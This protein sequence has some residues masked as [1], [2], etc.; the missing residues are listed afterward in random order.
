MEIVQTV[1]ETTHKTC[2]YRRITIHLQDKLG[3]RINHKA[4]FRL[5]RKLGIRSV[6]RQPYPYWK[7]QNLG[8]FHRYENLLNRDFVAQA[9]NQKW[10]TGNVN[11]AAG[12]IAT[13]HTVTG[14][15]ASE[16]K[17]LFDGLYAEIDHRVTTSAADKE[18]IKAEVKEI[19]STVTQAT[20]K[21]EKVD[22]G[23]LSSCFRNIARMAPDVLDLVVATLGNPVAGLGVAVKKI[24]D[25]A[26]GETSLPKS[27]QK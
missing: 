24:A 15:S 26:K 8:T 14:L 20:W 10:V 9:P 23:F 3:M 1:Y 17:G 16:I 2:G 6:A 13:H 27:A 12:N 19:E 21:N 25:R 22:D 7:M 5:M 4:V 18:D 11:V